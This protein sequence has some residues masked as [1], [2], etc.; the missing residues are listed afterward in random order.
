MTDCIKYLEEN[1]YI[2]KNPTEKSVELRN[3]AV[4]YANHLLNKNDKII[5][6]VLT[7][8]SVGGYSGN[9]SDIDLDVL[10]DGKKKSIKKVMYKNVTVD[11]QYKSYQEWKDDCLNN[12][13]EIKYITHT[14]PIVDNTG[15][16]QKM[17]MQLLTEYYSLDNMK[18]HYINIGNLIKGRCVEG[19]R[20]AE[21]GDFISSAFIIESALYEA[22]SMLIY[23][24]KGF[25]STSLM[26][27]EL[28]KISK[29]LKH[30]EWFHKTIEYMRFDISTEKTH[31]YIK[32]YG[33]IYSKMRKMLSENTDISKRIK[34]LKLGYFSAGNLLNELCS[35][36]N[37]IQL[38]D[39]VNRA[40]EKED[41]YD[42][43]LNLWFETHFNFL[44]FTP[45]FYLKNVNRNAYSKEITSKSFQMLF[46]FWDEEIRVLWCEVYGASVLT[47]ELL[48]NMSELSLEILSYCSC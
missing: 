27:S 5:A 11:L 28:E 17:Q 15:E 22:I 18:A 14:V 31:K 45:F 2:I 40:L 23:R 48:I 34:R 16:F 7:G 1:N 32:S 39:K 9:G 41:N 30:I 3:I 44:V 24:Y 35:E 43:G 47:E 10:V 8:S 37:Y 25:T 42:I 33:E 20:D 4:E 21:N 26:L 19:V 13:E 12:G 36:T 29:S 46:N 38:C 6:I